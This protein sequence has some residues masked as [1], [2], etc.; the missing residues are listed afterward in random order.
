[1]KRLLSAIFILALAF[2]QA[3]ATDP[4]VLKFRIGAF[5]TRSGMPSYKNLGLDRTAAVKS[6]EA[7][8][9]LVQFTGPVTDAWRDMVKAKGCKVFDY[10]PNYAHVVKMTPEQA[11][12]IK[13]L[14]PVTFVGYY[15]PAFRINPDLLSPQTPLEN[16]ESGRIQLNVLTFGVSDRAV[17][18]DRLL[19]DADVRFLQE[20]GNGRMFQVSIPEARSVEISKALANYPEVRWVE[21]K[22]PEVLHNSWSRWI[23]QSRDTTGMGSSATTWASKL[24]IQT[25]DDSLK[26]PIYR[27]GLYGQGQ[28]VHVDDTGMDWD[29][30]Y[31]RDPG[32][33]KPIYDKDLDTIM[34]ATNAHR[35]IVGYN[36]YADTFD[37]NASGHGTH[38]TGSVAADSLGWTAASGILPRA[39]GMAPMA[40]IAFTD[41]G[42]ASDALVLPTNY[43]TIY[44][45]GYNAGARISSSSWGQSAGGSS[46]YTANCEQLDTVAWQHQDYLM[47][48]SAGNSNTAATADNVNSP[49]TGKNIICNGANESGFGDGTAWSATGGTSR[50]EIK[51]VAEFSSH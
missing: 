38:T 20:D 34:E 21:R 32:G 23:N 45:W 46:A 33:L 29:N 11:E 30:V 9:Y 2:S 47:I 3:L 18:R 41:I 26:M 4:S 28:I 49:A 15:Q 24:R 31:F 10:I 27:R 14:S 51:D 37:L 6:G 1:M 39:Q 43:A 25:A 36:V 5:S 13:G 40:R 44:R 12:Q 22:Y 8:Y 42:G 7:A 48:R 50:N 35:K 17:V 19:G 16:E